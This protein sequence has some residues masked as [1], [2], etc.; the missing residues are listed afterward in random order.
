MCME[1]IRLVKMGKHLEYQRVSV[2]EALP[3]SYTERLQDCLF[4][5]IK[6]CRGMRR[7][8]SRMFAGLLKLVGFKKGTPRQERSIGEWDEKINHVGFPS[9]VVP[10]CNAGETEARVLLDTSKVVP[11]WNT[12]ET[13]A[14][15][16]LDTSELVPDWNTGETEARVLLDTL[17]LVPDWN[18]GETEARVLLDRSGAC[19]LRDSSD[20]W[21][22]A[23]GSC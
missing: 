23:G 16:L 5:F 11:D 3:R 15:V 10:D 2:D 20:S 21:D 9:K 22:M 4:S 6:L 8:I 19:D 18:A 17:E 12:G 14:R 13:E 7:S 1:F